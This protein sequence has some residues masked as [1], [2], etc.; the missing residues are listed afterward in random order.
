[1]AYTITKEVFEIFREFEQQTT[2]PKRK[3]VLLKY[4][5]NPAFKDVLRG[6]FDESLVFILPEGKPPYTP[7]RPE[8]TPSTLLREHR[9]FGYFVKNGPGQQMQAFKREKIFIEMLESIHPDDAL[10]VLSM[11]AKRSPVKNLT[12]K[13]VQEAFPNLIKR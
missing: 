1:M 12:K 10:I 6:T 7:N 11:I 4:K 9:K 3:E 5:D 2:R 8:S 13:L